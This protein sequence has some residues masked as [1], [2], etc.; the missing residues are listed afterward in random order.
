MGCFGGTGASAKTSEQPVK[1]RRDANS[2]AIDG[3]AGE[4]KGKNVFGIS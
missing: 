3:N 1:T 4:R 2:Y